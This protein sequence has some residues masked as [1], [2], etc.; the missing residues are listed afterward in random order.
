MPTACLRKDPNDYRLLK[1][2][3]FRQLIHITAASDL[4]KPTEREQAE[5]LVQLLAKAEPE[6]NSHISASVPKKCFCSCPEIEDA[7]WNLQNHNKWP[8]AAIRWFD[9]WKSFL[10]DI[11][12]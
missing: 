10:E 8:G 7:K 6:I 1:P 11:C 2:D 12:H 4:T 3:L 5:E 9:G